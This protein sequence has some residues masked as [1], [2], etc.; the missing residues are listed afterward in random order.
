[1]LLN[2]RTGQIV[3]AFANDLAEVAEQVRKG[4]LTVTGADMSYGG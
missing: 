2:Y 3:E 1:M 4:T